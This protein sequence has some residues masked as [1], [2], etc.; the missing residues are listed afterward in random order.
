V[1]VEAIDAQAGKVQ[2][3]DSGDS[4]QFRHEPLRHVPGQRPHFVP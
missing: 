1:V 2:V 3:V 4:R